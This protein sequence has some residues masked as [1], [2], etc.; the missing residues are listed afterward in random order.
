MAKSS[1]SVLQKLRLLWH[2]FLDPRTPAKAK[3]LVFLGLLY[4]VS[5]LDAVPDILPM[6]GQLDDIGV[7]IV[8]LLFFLRMTKTVRRELAK[9][10]VIDI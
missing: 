8:V 1:S 6:L 4:G 9:K 10:D 3:I 7:L 5:P 2:A